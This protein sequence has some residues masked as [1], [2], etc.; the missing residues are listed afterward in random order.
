[1]TDWKLTD[2]DKRMPVVTV[3]GTL[4]ATLATEPI[5][6]SSLAIIRVVEACSQVVL[7]SS[8]STSAPT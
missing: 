8:G 5:V 6:F 2:A 1:M 3:A 4:A 7:C